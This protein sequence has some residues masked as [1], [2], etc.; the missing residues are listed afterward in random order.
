MFY[1][2]NT[3]NK[4][5]DRIKLHLNESKNLIYNASKS[6]SFARH[7]ASHFNANAEVEDKN[8]MIKIGYAK[9]PMKM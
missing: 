4:V 7:F 9:K 3:Q 2:G 1:I 8:G 6:D 5:K